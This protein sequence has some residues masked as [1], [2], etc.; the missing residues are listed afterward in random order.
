[1]QS[2][3]VLYGTGPSRVPGTTLVLVRYSYKLPLSLRYSSSLYRSR[4]ASIYLGQQIGFRFVHVYLR[5]V[6]RHS[7]QQVVV[8]EERH[9]KVYVEVAVFDV[10]QGAGDGLFRRTISQP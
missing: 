8:V 5:V 1:M 2:S 7:L 9:V 6:R 3:C 4:Y 10:V